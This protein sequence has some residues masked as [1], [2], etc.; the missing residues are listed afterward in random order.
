MKYEV[1]YT[2][3]FKKDY[4]LCKSRGYRMSLL[5]DVIDLLRNGET[6]PEKYDDHALQG[7]YV[8]YRDCHIQ[9]D[10]VLIYRY[11]DDVLILTITRTGTHSDLF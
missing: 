10:W 8:G 4:K 5:T 9:N 7:N 11:D 6:L 1:R 3:M 2:A